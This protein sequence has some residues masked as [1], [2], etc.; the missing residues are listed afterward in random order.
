MSN[1]NING[2]SI[3]ELADNIRKLE[4]AISQL[5]QAKDAISSALTARTKDALA[6]ALAEA[7]KTQGSITAEVDGVK[8]SYELKPKISWDS[9]RLQAIAGDMAWDKV[10]KIF[11]IKFSVKE[12][13][14]KAL[15]DDALIASL[16][17]A[18]T[19]E[20]TEAKISLA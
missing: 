13:T 4:T 19:V 3:Q 6:A 2:A 12:T 17:E 1:I 11:S 7:G 15:T 9:K 14:F 5:E 10:E 18:R 16:N 20:H 8:L